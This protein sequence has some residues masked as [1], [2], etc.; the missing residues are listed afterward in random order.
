MTFG[1]CTLLLGTSTSTSTKQ[2]YNNAFL[3]G[4]LRTGL[5]EYLKYNTGTLNCFYLVVVVVVIT[6][7]CMVLEDVF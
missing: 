4:I 2:G 6:C 3:V 5:E 7:M 1:Q